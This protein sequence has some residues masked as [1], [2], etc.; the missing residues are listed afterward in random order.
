M[1]KPVLSFPLLSAHKFYIFRSE[2]IEDTMVI[3][4]AGVEE[5]GEEVVILTIEC[6]RVFV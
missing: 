1:V 3:D 5:G 6:P 4:D 2:T